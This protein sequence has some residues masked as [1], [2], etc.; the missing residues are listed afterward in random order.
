MFYANIYLNGSGA[1]RETGALRF[2]LSRRAHLLTTGPQARRW[3][4][5]RWSGCALC[6]TD[7]TLCGERQPMLP[8][9]W[10][11]SSLP[12]RRDRFAVPFACENLHPAALSQRQ[13]ESRMIA[14]LSLCRKRNRKRK[15]NR[16]ENDWQFTIWKRRS[17]AEAPGAR[18]VRHRPI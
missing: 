1:F 18:L 12:A 16:G 8:R 6:E 4:P 5:S 17:S 13:G 14:L 15:K 2:L 7:C 10:S 11:R 3:Q 9:L